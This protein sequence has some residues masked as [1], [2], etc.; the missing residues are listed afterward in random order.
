MIH[1]HST[2][3]LFPIT[4][5]PTRS[6]HHCML[7]AILFL[8][9]AVHAAVIAINEA[10]D[11]DDP[12]TTLHSLKIPEAHLTNLNE[13]MAEAYQTLLHDAKLEKA[14]VARN[15]VRCISS[16]DSMLCI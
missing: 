1:H 3:I 14:E 7:G 13:D 16:N 4:S 10:I 8:D 9:C 6:T 15:K 11:H 12:V 2:N 5:A